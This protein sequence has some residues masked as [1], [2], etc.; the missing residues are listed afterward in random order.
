MSNNVLRFLRASM[1][2]GIAG[3]AVICSS[4]LVLAQTRD[5]F[6]T[7]AADPGPRPLTAA[8][9]KL[10]ATN[11]KTQLSLSQES[12]TPMDSNTQ[13]FF[14][15]AS[16]RFQ[17]VD[18]VSGGITTPF[19]EN[20]N[21]LGPRFNANSCA[22]C[23]VFPTVGGT[24]PPGNFVTHDA[25]GRTITGNPQ[26]SVATLDGATNS[27][28]SFVTANGPVREARF[29][30]NPDGTPDGGVHDLFTITGRTDAAGCRLAQP[31][32]AQ[33]LTNNN[34]IFRIPTP[35]FGLGLVEN[36]P[37]GDQDPT[38]GLQGAVN[39]QATL[40]SNLGISG[41]FNRSGNDGTITRFG[42]KAQNKS[43]LIFAGEAY[44]VE[45]G[46]SNELFPNERDDTAGCRINPTP[47]DA[48]NVVN[49]RNTASPA[50]D[51]SSDT[52]NFAAFMRF[53]GPPLPATPL[54]FSQSRGQ[55]VFLNIGC[56]AC[57]IQSQTTSPSSVDNVDANGNPV[58]PT[59]VTF[60]PFSDFQIHSMGDGLQ[61][62]V[63]QGNAEGDEFRTAPL[64]GV[65]QRVFFLHD[66]R[67]SDLK[68]A[69]LAHFSAT[70][71]NRTGQPIPGS[72]SEANQVI[73]NFNALSDADRQN[74]LNFLRAL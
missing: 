18:S 14:N 34:V 41:T 23:H 44:N 56:G 21:G 31:N 19:P 20:G 37:D 51:F 73:N 5:G 12:V 49:T 74:L 63:S 7:S 72:G 26:V 6:S 38:I 16:V 8:Q 69:I 47:E 43:L 48:T 42:W 59:P 66:G 25:S 46:V 24:S 50:S 62:G 28:P 45:Q 60:Q 68:Q 67:T 61:D 29:V 10:N 9:A 3:A 65:G 33:Q 39:G 57:H 27:L 58:N 22:S 15:S 71:T 11:P 1:L 40:R 32:F 64:W 55:T 53:S 17:E 4:G 30:R 35:T 13:N 54:N 70:E 52:V 36:T 2:T